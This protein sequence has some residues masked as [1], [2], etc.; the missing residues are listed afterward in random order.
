MGISQNQAR[1]LSKKDDF[2]TASARV[3]PAVFQKHPAVVPSKAPDARSEQRPYILWQHDRGVV[4][5]Q[6]FHHGSMPL[7]LAGSQLL[8]SRAPVAAMLGL[9]LGTSAQYCWQQIPSDPGPGM[10]AARSSSLMHTQTMTL[11]RPRPTSL[12]AVALREVYLATDAQQIWYLL[13]CPKN[14]CTAT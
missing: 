6:A 1:V 13:Y 3:Q 5:A 12:S 7:V 8:A 14:I 11:R 9:Q 4:K 10:P 2:L